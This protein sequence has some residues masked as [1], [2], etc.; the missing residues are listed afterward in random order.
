LPEEGAAAALCPA[1][2]SL[3]GSGD[4]EREGSRSQSERPGPGCR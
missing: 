4:E 3:P 1:A 2:I